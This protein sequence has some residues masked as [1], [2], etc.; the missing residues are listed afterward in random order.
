MP[1]SVCLTVTLLCLPGG[2]SVRISWSEILTWAFFNNST[3]QG[4]KRS[5]PLKDVIGA[6]GTRDVLGDGPEHSSPAHARGLL[7]RWTG[8]W[9][10]LAGLRAE[11]E[12][13]GRKGETRGR[14]IVGCVQGMDL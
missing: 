13:T 11:S 10:D 8:M 2:H 14:K 3:G 7:L 1:E 6:M 5:E 4:T 12:R 9:E